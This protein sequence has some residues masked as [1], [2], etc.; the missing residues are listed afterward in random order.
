[1]SSEGTY[2]R[3]LVTGR[4]DGEFTYKGVV[5]HVKAET[6]SRW[7]GKCRPESPIVYGPVSVKR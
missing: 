3:K 4:H 6:V 1:M 2:S 7:I 5:V